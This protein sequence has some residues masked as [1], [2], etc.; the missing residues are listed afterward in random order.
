M[1]AILLAGI[2]YLF[3]ALKRVA[4]DA[5]SGDGYREHGV[6]KKLYFFACLAPLLPLLPL[7][8]ALCPVWAPFRPP[9]SSLWA[10]SFCQLL[11]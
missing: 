2:H 7:C 5:E 4:V 8:P 3:T 1:I 9:T 11:T 10:L 6:A